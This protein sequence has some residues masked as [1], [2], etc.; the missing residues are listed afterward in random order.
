MRFLYNQ[1]NTLFFFI[2]LSGLPF[3]AVG[4]NAAQESVLSR[5]TWFKIAVVE[6]AV[7]K[8]D[9]TTLSTM[10]IDMQGLNP[11]KI[12]IFGNEA[13][14]L[15]ET[16]SDSRYDDLTEMAIYVS[17]AED[18]VFNAE[19]FVLFYGQETMTWALETIKN[20]R[21]SII[22]YDDDKLE[23]ISYSNQRNPYSDTSY[24]FLSVDTGVD[25]LRIQER[26]AGTVENVSTV[27]TEFL[28][29]RLHETDLMNPYASGRD[30]YGEMMT[31]S[32]PSLE[33]AFNLPGLIK[34]EPI[35]TEVKLFGRCSQSHY[36]DIFANDALVVDSLEFNKNSSYVYGVEKTIS[37][38]IYSDSDAYKIRVDLKPNASG[39]SLYLDYIKLNFWRQLR[40]HGGMMHFRVISSQMQSKSVGVKMENVPESFFLWNVSSPLRP[41]RQM[42][43]KEDDA[44]LF[45][46]SEAA[47]KRYILFT[48]ADVLSICSAYEIPNQNLHAIQDAD[49]LIIT[50]PVF[51]SQAQ[52]L[53]DF[54]A[55]HDALN[56]LVV[57]IDEIYNEF[58]S[59][60]CDI[61]GIRDFIRMVYSR[62][63]HNLKYVLL[64]GKA[65][66][67]Y[68]NI[69]GHGNN[70]VPCYEFPRLVYHQVQSMCSDDYFGLM[71]ALEGAECKGYMDLGVGR[72]PVTTVEQAKA[73]VDKVRH[74]S[75]KSATAGYWKNNH[76]FFAD[77]G[78]NYVDQGELCSRIIDTACHNMTIK[79]LY[80]DSYPRVNTPSGYAFPEANKALM[81]TFDEGVLTTSYIGHGGVKG[82]TA[83]GVFTISD[84][85]SMKNLDNMVFMHTA[86]C[87]FSK[88]DDP[89]N[90]SAGEQMFFKQDGGAIALLTTTRPTFG[91]NNFSF[92]KS[93]SVHL[94]NSRN[95]EANRF[96]DIVRETK[97]DRTYYKTPN[98]VYVLFGDPALRLAYPDEDV[99]TTKVNGHVSSTLLKI[100]ALDV[101]TF[102]GEIRD[103]AGDVDTAFNGYLYPRFYDKQTAQTTLG[104]ASS[105]SII[106]YSSFEDILYEGK[107]TV[108]N[109]KFSFSFQVPY[110][111]NYTY[112]EP[113]MSYYAY[114]SIRKI[115]AN[116]VFE[117]LSLGGINEA[118][119]IDN[120]G[121]EIKFYWDQPS[122]ENGDTV[123]RQ[124]VLYAELFDKQGIYHYN[125]N[126][127]RDIVLTSNVQNQASVVLNSYYEPALDDFTRGKVVFPISNLAPGTYEFNLKA[128]DNQ[129]N[130][131][132]A[133]I[134]LVVAENAV[135]A[136]ISN[137]PNPFSPQTHIE[138]HFVF[139][140]QL[141]DAT[142]DVTIE[143]FDVLGQKVA[144]IETQAVSTGDGVEPVPWDGKGYGGQLLSSGIY[145]YKITVDDENGNPHSACQRLI[146][147]R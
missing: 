62:S 18:G 117:N 139:T 42:S 93:F 16:C 119:E 140:H 132:E 11:D 44:I 124:G 14:V 22:D 6:D 35:I 15:P 122:F 116:G 79:K 34:T 56:C 90:I 85:L 58:S 66:F 54:H 49:M 17:G 53:A 99:A 144:N 136:N 118:A 95:A 36:C 70:F 120:V 103:R 63:V 147:V 25:G 102:E 146:I 100:H 126:I 97:A 87:E 123:K 41:Y 83:E 78:S 74:Y 130:P 52:E 69:K 57:N 109:G 45:A 88:F 127:G 7:Y 114:D 115:D 105:S 21:D 80:I 27:L 4:Q 39:P 86:T 142:V 101:L 32:N 23:R 110:N 89:S 104:N 65:S 134:W 143:V 59:G 33:I 9:Y 3:V 19:D 71:D 29:Y 60:S 131:S 129:N 111:I 81:S 92:S 91:S 47:E 40:Y 96:G 8:L 46:E 38:S 12:R 48:D 43:V 138:T 1:I 68:R 61:T 37:K 112:G 73:A 26:A 13:G 50:P 67:D 125:F 20:D 75:D 2:V 137:Y 145:V 128:W 113:R 133:K 30:W 121:P 5:N 28:D 51:I 76:L 84:I 107:I 77:D 64:F 55:Q 94:Y 106:S 10:G 135:L 82:L 24:Y 108:R 31:E 98:V 72:F 141:D